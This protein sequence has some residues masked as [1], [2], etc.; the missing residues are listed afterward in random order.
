MEPPV[1]PS[2]IHRRRRG[3]PGGIDDPT[4]DQ[5]ADVPSARRQRVRVRGIA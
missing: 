5:R 4:T 1:R 2:P 3:Q